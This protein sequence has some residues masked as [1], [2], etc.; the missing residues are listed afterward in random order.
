MRQ[1]VLT[2]VVGL[3]SSATAFGQ[4]D[5]SNK[6]KFQSGAELRNQ[7]E[8]K[9]DQTLTIAGMAIETKVEQFLV[10]VDKVREVAPDGGATTARKT[11]TMQFNLTAPGGL[12]LNFDSGNPNQAGTNPLLQPLA[13]SLKK[14]AAAELVTTYGADGKVTSI[15]WSSDLASQ[16]DDSIKG[17]IDPENLKREANQDLDRLPNKVV[18]VGDTW[19]RTE[20]MGL[21]QGQKMTF[22]IDYT[23]TGPAEVN[24]KKVEQIGVKIKSVKLTVENNPQFEFKNTELEVKDSKGTLSYDPAVGMVTSSDNTIHIAGKLTMV[25]NGMELP[26]ELDLTIGAKSTL[27]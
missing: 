17:Q 20:E 14:M 11:E 26:S 6:P 24:G 15:Q 10:N 23:Y 19:S 27:Q 18:N 8:L 1:V 2:F 22:D 7:V 3:L 5:L 4:A 21:G 9:V 25:V 12:S 16:V 13:D